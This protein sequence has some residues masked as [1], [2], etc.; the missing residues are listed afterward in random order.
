MKSISLAFSS[1]RLVVLGSHWQII[2]ATHVSRKGIES[3]M[4]C[5]ALFLQG[6][7]NSC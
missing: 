6:S 4:H 3:V 7:N 5:S 2:P 1:L